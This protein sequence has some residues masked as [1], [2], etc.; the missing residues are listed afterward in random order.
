MKLLEQVHNALRLKHYSFCTEQCYVRWICQ[1]IHFHKQAE[2]FRHPATLGASMRKP[3][4]GTA[5]CRDCWRAARR[6]FSRPVAAAQPIYTT[7][8]TRRSL[9]RATDSFVAFGFSSRRRWQPVIEYDDRQ[10]ADGQVA[11]GG[12]VDG[13]TL[14]K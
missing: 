6:V 9:P 2:G 5:S 14:V 13:G 12:R 7:A 1:Y 8:R 4:T 3:T 11:S 10:E